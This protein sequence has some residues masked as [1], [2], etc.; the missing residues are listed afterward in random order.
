MSAGGP[1]GGRAAVG[2]VESAVLLGAATLGLATAGGLLQQALGYPGLVATELL[3]VLAPTLVVARMARA[4]PAA[5]GLMW[6]SLASLAGGA[7]A[8][9]GAFYL[10]A[11]VIE[12]AIDRLVPPPPALQDH[13]ARLIVPASGV[14]PLAVDLFVLA[15]TPAVCEELLFRGAL[16]AS[17]R[18]H[19]RP[20]LA[21]LASG[22]AFG[23]FHLSFYK[24]VPLA[25]IGTLAAAVTLRARSIGPAIVLHFMNNLL[26]V[27]FVRAGI[28]PPPVG[29]RAGL[30]WLAAALGAVAAGVWLAH[31]SRGNLRAT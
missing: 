22:L 4:S 18:A 15:L 31:P 2:L 23:A 20:A 17:F 6:P 16:L 30:L 1:G 27:L 9:A 28:E 24:L 25:A 12:A 8:G 26:V 3:I 13:L 11:A 29:S 10:S 14:R 5:L 19:T 7:L 21:A